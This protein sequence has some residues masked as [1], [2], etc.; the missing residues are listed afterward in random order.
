MH[1][2]NIVKDK[3][4]Q[5][6]K[7]ERTPKV[8]KL[9]RIFASVIY[10]IL[11]LLLA[12]TLGTTEKG[13]KTMTHKFVESKTVDEK[14]YEHYIEYGF[15]ED[16][17]K[18]I[19]EGEEIKYLTADVMVERMR[20]IFRDTKSYKISLDEAKESIRKI[21]FDAAAEQG[22]ELDDNA[23]S[24]L[25]DYTADISGISTMF[26]YDTP[27]E[28]RTAIFDTSKEDAEMSNSLLSILATLSSP[29]FMILLLV[30]FII[31][32]VILYFL[33]TR[34]KKFSFL[35]VTLYPSLAL[36]GFSIGEI[37]MP[38]APA[39][40]DYVFRLISISSIIGVLFGVGIFFLI[41]LLESRGKD[42]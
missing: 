25:V 30:M 7:R 28:Y 29:L 11:I 36:L 21:L 40:T 38:D 5:F 41:R 9:L 37:F 27:A 31:I 8:V 35:N 14:Y 42:D 26:W 19:L 2:S 13:L 20:A 6:S 34:E 33:D 32:M 4:E 15:S 18:R 3:I 1:L 39:I 17:C 22:L 10:F 16:S 24:A 12:L 23:L